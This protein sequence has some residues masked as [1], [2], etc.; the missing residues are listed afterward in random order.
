MSER[1]WDEHLAWCKERAFEYVDRG[2][3]REGLTS[4]FSDVS[5]H[6]RGKNHPG[7]QMGIGL[8]VI[9][10]LSSPREARRFIEGFN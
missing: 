10:A 4:M 7:I 1:S 3:I 6:E 8:M 9:G 5:K 2:E